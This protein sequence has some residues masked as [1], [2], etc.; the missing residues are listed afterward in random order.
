MLTESNY[1]EE[2]LLSELPGAMS[3]EAITVLSG[4]NITVP[5]TVL[6]KVTVGAA[7]SAAFGGNTGNGTMG[8]VTLSVG[9]KAGVYKLTIIEPGS[10]VGTFI[11]EN[12]DGVQIGRGVVASA[13]S[14]G[15]LAFTLADGAT[16]FVAGDGFNITVAAGSGKYVKYN[17]DATNGSQIA[18]GIAIDAYDATL[19]D[20][21]GVAL[22]RGC[23]VADDSLTWPSDIDGGEKTAA[24]AQLAALNPPILVRTA[25]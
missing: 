11:V 7:T 15:G 8:A 9:A 1:R 16:D 25:I 3:R 13:F 22:V 14:A 5:M 17:Q 23:E 6:G 4:Q 21:D 12:P 19:A 20:V 18:A 24:I 10:N 2:G